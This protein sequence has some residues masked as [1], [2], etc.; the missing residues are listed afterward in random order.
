MTATT[1][2]HYGVKPSNVQLDHKHQINYLFY[3]TTDV[4]FQK[5]CRFLVISHYFKDLHPMIRKL[6]GKPSALSDGELKDIYDFYF[7]QNLL[8][9]DQYKKLAHSSNS[10]VLLTTL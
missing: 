1:D 2:E 8:T 10:N 5:L 6:G 7:E 3:P 4:S 9:S